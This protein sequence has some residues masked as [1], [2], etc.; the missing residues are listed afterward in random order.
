[1]LASIWRIF[2]L[3]S[4]LCSISLPAHALIILSAE[5]DSPAV[6]SFTQE[7]A[8]ALPEH[9]IKYVPRPQLVTQENFSA[10]TQLILL[11]PKLLDWRLQLS[12][13]SPATLI[14]QVSRVQAYK[15]LANQQPQHLTFLWNDPPVSRQIALLKAMQPD[16]QNI[17]VLYGNHSSFLLK[18]TEQAMQAEGLTL[19]K[20]YWPDSY[21]AR[22]LAFLLSQTDALL[23]LDDA[24][25]YNPTTIKSILLSSYARKQALIGPTAAFIKAGS[26]SSTYSDKDD[27]LHSLQVLLQMP[28]DTWPHSF[29]PEEFK[30]RVNQQ[31]ARSLRIQNMRPQKLK[32]QLKQARPTP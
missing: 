14:M 32:K 2:C 13:S 12:K 22:S 29:Y 26:L 18:E 8:Q 4:V 16:L 9:S 5:Y 24:N 19:H 20:Y 7:L 27:W 30:V 31:V 21:D 15:R 25:I 3:C 17:G 6:R 23:G 1:M 28:S 11:G 10:D